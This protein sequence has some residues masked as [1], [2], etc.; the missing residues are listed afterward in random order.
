VL[1]S[2]KSCFTCSN[3][4]KRFFFSLVNTSMTSYKII[5]ITV[6]PALVTTSVKQ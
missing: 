4:F 3:S 2:Y 5:N 1:S 6:K